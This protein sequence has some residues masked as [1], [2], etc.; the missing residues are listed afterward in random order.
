MVPRLA[1]ARTACL[2][3]ARAA[4]FAAAGPRRDAYGFFG[5]VYSA[6]FWNG[7]HTVS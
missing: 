7:S 4:R 3:D 2:H 1:G 6:S 5:V